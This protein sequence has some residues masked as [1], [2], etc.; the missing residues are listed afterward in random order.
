MGEESVA[1]VV[2]G[3]AINLEDEPMMKKTGCSFLALPV[4][5]LPLF[6]LLGACGAQ[7]PVPDTAADLA[8]EVEVPVDTKADSTTSLIGTYRGKDAVSLLVLKTD[9]GFR[10]EMPCPPNARCSTPT[11]SFDGTFRTTRSGS[12]IRYLV[13]TGGGAEWRF[14]YQQEAARGGLALRQVYTTAWSSLSRPEQAWCAA[15]SDCRLQNV[16]T[17]ACVGEHTC[18]RSACGFVCR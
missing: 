5:A 1:W 16:V 12:G 10:L 14:A 11:L 8:T 3:E 7:D 2:H 9:K 13:L 18:A 6:A 15:P 17:P 4:L